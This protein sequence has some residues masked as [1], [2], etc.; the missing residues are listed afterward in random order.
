M[1]TGSDLFPKVKGVKLIRGPLHVSGPYSVYVGYIENKDDSD[2]PHY[3]VLN[4]EHIV[5]EG[6][7]HNFHI[8]RQIAD[9]LENVANKKPELPGESVESGKFN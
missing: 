7:T 1:P 3:L 4:S 8:A 2:L 6:S 9:E 5:V